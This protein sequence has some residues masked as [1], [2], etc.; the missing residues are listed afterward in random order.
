MSGRSVRRG[1]LV[2][3]EGIDGAGKSTFVRALVRRLRARGH[4]VRSAREPLRSELGRAGA[5]A[6][7]TDPWRAALWFTLDRAFARPHLERALA[8]C[9]LLIQDRSFYSTLAYQGSRLPPSGRRLLEAFERAVALAPDVVLFLD[10]DPRTALARL[11][12]R[13]SA[14]APL[15]RRAVLERTAT[16]YRRLAKRPGWCRIDGRAP[17]AESVAR[18]THRLEARLRRPRRPRSEANLPNRRARPR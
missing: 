16:A 17:P 9:D 11:D 15:E 12:R 3:V 8:D 18:A 2:A 6:N 1:L 13:G 5:L 4:S 7:A 10:V 14:R